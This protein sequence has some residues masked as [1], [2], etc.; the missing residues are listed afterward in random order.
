TPP[1][2]ID[3]LDF[4]PGANGIGGTFT[5]AGSQD[6]RYQIIID[7]SRD[8]VFAFDSDVVLSG[9]TVAGANSVAWDGLDPQ[10]QPADPEICYQTLAQG[11]AGETHIPLYDAEENPNGF[12]IER[13][14]GPDV[15]DYRIY[16]NDVPIGGGQAI[17]GEISSSG[18]HKWSVVPGGDPDG[19]GNQ[20]GIDTWAYAVGEPA[21][22]NACTVTQIEAHKSDRLFADNDADG[23]PSPGDELE[24]TIAIE[25]AGQTDAV[26]TVFS[27]IPGAYTTLVTGT[28]ATTLGTVMA[29][30]GVGDTSVQVDLG[31]LEK[32]AP[33]TITFRVRA[34]P[35][36]A[37]RGVSQ[38]ANQGFVSAGNTPTAH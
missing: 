2:A 31:M 9:D 30:N 8:G 10:G 35:R 3:G 38:V 32:T 36:Y 22:V 25:N 13:L 26:G 17:N 34:S 6:G 19:F 15:P 27:D 7:T 24:Y 21:F 28:V 16:Y 4:T 20:R 12:I 5:F 37:A 29:G 18:G 11:I 33:V 23:L 14:N 1:I